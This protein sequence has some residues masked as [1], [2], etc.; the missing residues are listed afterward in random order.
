MMF[1]RAA[2]H[3]LCL[4]AGS[5]ALPTL[6]DKPVSFEKDVLP[7]LN[8]SCAGCHQPGKLKGGLDVTTHKAV[9]TGGKNGIAVKPGEATK[10]PLVTMTL[11]DPP[12]MPSKGDPLSKKEIATLTRWVNEGAKDD[13]TAVA[14][15][16]SGAI[17]GP[18]PLPAPP[19]YSAAP[20]I[21]AIAY[22]PDGSLI[23]VGGYYETIL[24]KADGTG[25]AARLV[26]GSPRVLAMSFSTDGKRLATAGGA[27]G[28]YGHVQI[29]NLET[30]SLAGSWKYTADTVFG[31]NFSPDGSQLAFGCADKS[32]RVISAADGK[33]LLKLDQ[34]TDWC[35]GALFTVD[36]KRLLSAGRDQAMKLTAIAN[37][38]FIDDVN[39]PL[40]PIMAIA[41]HPKEDQVL[42]GGANGGVRVYKIADN[43]A[44]TAGRNDTNLVKDF[45]R[46]P[47]GVHGVA[48]SADGAR[49]AVGS[50]GEAR[51]Y[52]AK[53]GSKVATLPG[54]DG[55]VFAVSF[56]PDGKRLVTGGYDG[57]VRI[58]DV[59]SGKLVTSFVPVPIGK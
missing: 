14:A 53:S 29:W 26:G 31:I 34:H 59:P 35:L 52:D 5:S 10:S 25:I 47:A 24:H 3:A 42:Y 9:M 1:R 18:A 36:G 27:P 37:G 12:E 6:A 39:N 40:D 41:R 38:Q 22:S 4:I 57:N 54:H 30:K 58:F 15:T 50:V 55:G 44:R 45:E 48:W 19:T 49:I 17:P 46:Q 33:E 56:S 21:G 43:Q 32:A 23:A 13:S 7:I 51:V 16:A 11:G 8:A 2:F 20:V 28:Q